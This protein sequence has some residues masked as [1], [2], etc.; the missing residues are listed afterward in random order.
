MVVGVSV[1]FCAL[2]MIGMLQSKV[3]FLALM[4]ALILLGSLLV[5]DFLRKRHQSSILRSV[6]I[7]GIVGCI[8]MT[9]GF[10][11]SRPL[12]RA[13]R[14]HMDE[15]MD[16]IRSGARFEARASSSQARV[17]LYYES[18]QLLREHWLLGV[19]P[20]NWRF[21][22]PCTGIKQFD[23]QVKDGIMNF[24]R[25]HSDVLQV[26]TEV[27]L[28]NLFLLLAL[29]AYGIRTGIKRLREKQDGLTW[30]TAIIT[31]LIMGYSMVLIF[32]FTM[33]RPTHLFLLMCNLVLLFAGTRTGAKPGQRTSWISIASGTILAGIALYIAC[34]NIKGEMIS[35]QL[36]TSDYQE[37]MALESSARHFFYPTDPFGMPVQWYRGV[38]Y[39]AH[40][41]Y[42]EAVSAFEAALTIQPCQI[43]ILNN[44]AS[45]K[46]HTGDVEG[47]IETYR[48]ALRISPLFEESI[49]NLAALYYNNGD[50]ENALQT[51]RAAPEQ[52]EHPNYRLFLLTILRAYAKEIEP[53]LEINDE[54]LLWM[55]EKFRPRDLP[56]RDWVNAEFRNQSVSNQDLQEAE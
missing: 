10:Y 23:G 43:H 20:G 48:Q 22:F 45:A 8:G 46:L 47:A 14:I 53:R 9:A 25:A 28:V 56:F 40:T 55:Y 13:E 6:L 51:I 33:E 50:L 30:P 24:Q 7:V 32:D 54:D 42:A 4:T 27:G 16:K 52:S 44:L 21:C 26:A 31:A 1:G 36:R 41:N 5:Y 3:V 35:K 39:Y 34:V 49:M 19:G 29:I 17:L 18:A 2:I 15:A 37:T 12:L 11:L 38:A